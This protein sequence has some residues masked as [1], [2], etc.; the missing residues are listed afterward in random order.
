M[1]LF[2]AT[3]FFLTLA[4]AGVENQN[5]IALS[6]FKDGDLQVGKVTATEKRP[7]DNFI[8]Q[9][10]KTWPVKFVRD[11]NRVTQGW[12]P[13]NGNHCKQSRSGRR[14]IHP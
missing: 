2:I 9:A 14:K 7:N 4:P 11:G 10:A 3:F 12:K 5:Q 13:C 8:E 1:Q 6:Q